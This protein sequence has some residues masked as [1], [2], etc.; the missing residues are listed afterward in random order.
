[1]WQVG[2]EHR[3]LPKRDKHFRDKDVVVEFGGIRFLGEGLGMTLQA[4]WNPE[5]D[6]ELTGLP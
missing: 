1:L 4:P 3:Y 6:I 2:E 5:E